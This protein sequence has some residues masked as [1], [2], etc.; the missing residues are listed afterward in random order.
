MASLSEGGHTLS[1]TVVDLAGNSSSASSAFIVTV[2]TVAPTLLAA[3]SVNSAVL[4]LTF[5]E[6]VSLAAP[7]IRPPA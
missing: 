4:T 3:L 7:P 5:A 6:A 1:A 2:D